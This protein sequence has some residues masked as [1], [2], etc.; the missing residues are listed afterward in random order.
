MIAGRRVTTT[1]SKTGHWGHRAH[2]RDADSEVRSRHDRAL[3]GI[4]PFRGGRQRFGL[5]GTRCKEGELSERSGGVILYPVGKGI[6]ASLVPLAPKRVR[7]RK[8]EFAFPHPQPAM[9]SLKMRRESML[10]YSII[11]NLLPDYTPPNPA[12]PQTIPETQRPHSALSSNVNRQAF[13]KCST[14]FSTLDDDD[15]NT[16]ETLFTTATL[17]DNQVICKEGSRVDHVYV[18][19][20]GFLRVLKAFLPEEDDDRCSGPP[21]HASTAATGANSARRSSSTD[22]ENWLKH[23]DLGEI[24]PKE[25]LGE[26]GVLKHLDTSSVFSA[27]PA[28]AAAE[29]V[30][31]PA[32]TSNQED[33]QPLSRPIETPGDTTDHGA[34]PPDGDDGDASPPSTDAAADRAGSPRVAAMVPRKPAYIVSAA[35]SGG[36]AEVYVASVYD[37]KKLQTD[38]FR[39]C[40]KTAQRL[41]QARAQAWGVGALAQQLRR[42]NEWEA[43]KR[44]IISQI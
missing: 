14:V 41:H 40:W 32:I 24:G 3:F 33:A 38:S 16:V 27:A 8:T 9:R 26:N 11:N 35:A 44:E 39:Y 6:G 18:V 28:P 37:L 23:F 22:P 17:R 2:R 25:M 5:R 43:R 10:P 20:R 21:P 34:S 7:I 15:L 4:G 36:T 1:A 19:K 12:V 29:A 31:L 13:L 42:Q 30:T